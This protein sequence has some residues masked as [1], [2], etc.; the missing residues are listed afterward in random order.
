MLIVLE[1]A[2]EIKGCAAAIILIWLST[3]KNLLPILPHTFAQ[4]KTLRCSSFRWGA[5]SSVIDPQTWILAASISSFVKDKKLSISNEK[6]LSWSS[7]IFKI[8]LQNS[9]PKV[10]WLKTNLISK[11][12]SNEFSIKL[13]CS[14]LKPLSLR[15]EW[16]IDWQFFRLPVPKT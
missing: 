10:N 16:L 11:A 3:D 5:P 12:L 9:L 6:S 2:P 7:E 14:S 13:I 15:A 4:S 1:I 8:F